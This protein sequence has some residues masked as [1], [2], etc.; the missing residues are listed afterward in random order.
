MPS[1]ARAYRAQ[2]Q[3]EQR[4]TRRV[5]VRVVP[6]RASDAL[7]QGVKKAAFSLMA[8]VAVLAVIACVR[9][10][11]TAATVNTTMAT[12]SL[13]AQISELQSYAASLEIQES[14]LANPAYVRSEASGRLG[15]VAPGA[16]FHLDLG[17]DA[18]RYN[19]AGQLSLSSSLAAVAQG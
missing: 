9:I 3:R 13:S 8:I 5:A 15:M 10:G 4:A 11:F 17:M 18:V 6:G 14:M 1:A 16:S 2:P 19:E 12:E 7:P